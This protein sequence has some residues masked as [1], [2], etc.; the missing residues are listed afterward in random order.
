MKK[1]ILLILAALLVISSAVQAKPQFG[2]KAGLNIASASI[3]PMQQGIS[4]KSILGYMFAGTIEAPISQDKSF[5]LKGEV[6]YVEKG[7]KLSGNNGFLKG[8]IDELAFSPFLVYNVSGIVDNARPFIQVGPEFA[9]VLSANNHYEID[10]QGTSDEDNK[11][12]ADTDISLN[13][14]AGIGLPLGNKDEVVFDIR[15]CLGLSDMD[16]TSQVKTKLRS[17]MFCVGYNF[18]VKK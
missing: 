10:N 14:G 5:A 3:S 8:T 13:L 6:S 17:F 1:L 15:Y 4:K 11:D 16:N 12:A 18:P 7:A 9:F 2:I